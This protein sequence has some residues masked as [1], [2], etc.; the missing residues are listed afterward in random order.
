[1]GMRGRN[2]IMSHKELMLNKYFH[3]DVRAIEK[4]EVNC[5][6]D[7]VKIEFCPELN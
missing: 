6:N 2:L 7:V 4:F 1:M 3:M 5:V